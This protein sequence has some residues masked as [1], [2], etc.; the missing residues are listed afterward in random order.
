MERD[1][2]TSD[3]VGINWKQLVEQEER[4]RLSE[5]VR[6]KYREVENDSSYVDWIDYTARIIQP[7]ILKAVGLKP[8]A[9]N[10]LSLRVAAQETSA[11]WVKYNRARMGSL[12]NGS[13]VP[14][15]HVYSSKTVLFFNLENYYV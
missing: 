10:L 14:P 15:I 3:T 8:T 6:Q 4:M 5:E 1:K 9:A 13:L 7:N 2:R 12:R 11:Y